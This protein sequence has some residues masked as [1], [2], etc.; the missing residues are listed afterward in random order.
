MKQEYEITEKIPVDEF[1]DDGR[2]YNNCIKCGQNQYPLKH[3]MYCILC[4]ESNFLVDC[5]APKA[6]KHDTAMEA[7][8]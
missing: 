8:V 4:G 5:A 2:L 7:F 3:G 1:D 6:E